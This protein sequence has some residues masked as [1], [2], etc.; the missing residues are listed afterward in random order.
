MLFESLLYCF[1]SSKGLF[2]NPA[3]VGTS[4]LRDK[5]LLNR[6]LR[7]WHPDNLFDVALI[8]R[9]EAEDEIIFM[10]LEVDHDEPQNIQS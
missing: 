5:K 9:L 3:V 4:D 8:H 6:F 10:G 2:F 1:F 7:R